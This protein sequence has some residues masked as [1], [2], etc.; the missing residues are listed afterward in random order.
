MAAGM[1]FFLSLA[2]MSNWMRPWYPDS[3]IFLLVMFQ[4]YFH[5]SYL[6][7]ANSWTAGPEVIG[8]AM[9][10]ESI[11]YIFLLG[12]TLMI[13]RNKA[14]GR[15]ITCNSWLCIQAIKVSF[16]N[17]FRNFEKIFK[18]LEYVKKFNFTTRNFTWFMGIGWWNNFLKNTFSSS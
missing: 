1:N 13:S 18:T 14:Q 12:S 16:L 4:N 15:K 3:N 8:S 17:F 11:L 7:K 10:S 5:C 2:K 6:N 9:I